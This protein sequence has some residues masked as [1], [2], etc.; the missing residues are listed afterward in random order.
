MVN[1]RVELTARG[2]VLDDQEPYAS[3]PP[4]EGD[5]FARALHASFR[6]SLLGKLVPHMSGEEIDALLDVLL[7]ETVVRI[8]TEAETNK[9]EPS[10]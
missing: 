4:P 10:E 6:L 8:A 3:L 2:S 9:D 1:S 7:S 5:R